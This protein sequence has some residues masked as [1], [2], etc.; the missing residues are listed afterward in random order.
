MPNKFK[1]IYAQAYA[2]EFPER[3]CGDG[4]E[5]GRGNRSNMPGQYKHGTWIASRTY[6]KLNLTVG[7]NCF[8]FCASLGYPPVYT[9]IY[10]VNRCFQELSS[11]R[12][13]FAKAPLDIK[14]ILISPHVL[15]NRVVDDVSFRV[16]VNERVV[17]PGEDEELQLRQEMARWSQHRRR[18]LRVHLRS[19]REVI[20]TWDFLTLQKNKQ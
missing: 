5:V 19:S 15:F 16:F 13:Q 10:V 3:M 8:I 4:G 20:N 1:V 14:S 2:R 9:R 12:A 7:R 11:R 17:D 6:F 18:V